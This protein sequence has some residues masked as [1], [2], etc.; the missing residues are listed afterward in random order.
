MTSENEILIPER[1]LL[2]EYKNEDWLQN[3]IFNNPSV[4]GLGELDPI[5]REKRQPTGGRI[6]IVFE[7]TEKNILYE[8]EIQLG[9]T[10]ESHI[11]RT[12]EYW[13]VEKRRYPNY[14]HKAVIIAEEITSRFFNVIYLLNRY[15]PIVAI[16]M[17][18]LLI[19]GQLDLHFIKVL[20]TFI[21]PE[22]E[23]ESEAENVNEEYWASKTPEPNWEATQ[24][25]LTWFREIDNNLNVSFKKNNLPIGRRRNFLWI[26]P[27]KSNFMHLTFLILDEDVEEV[28]NLLQEMGITPTLQKKRSDT[29][30]IKFQ[31]YLNI[32][33]DKKEDILKIFEISRDGSA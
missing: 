17:E 33:N 27:R 25:L 11:I 7:D 24:K 4:L 8:V 18:A 2:R 20:D 30:H 15:I 29:T 12:I 22:E 5:K 3:Y 23:I 19:E 13:E 9:K 21:Q 26:R 28:E 14:N 16:K 32:I 10:D 6:D 1:V 31:L